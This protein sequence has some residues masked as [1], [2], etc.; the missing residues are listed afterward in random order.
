ML[1]KKWIKR[2]TPP[3]FCF[4]LVFFLCFFHLFFFFSFLATP[5]LLVGV[6]VHISLDQ[7]VAP[8]EG[9]DLLE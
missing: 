7:R 1:A 9:V 4:G 8:S 2:N 3:L 5:P 6:T